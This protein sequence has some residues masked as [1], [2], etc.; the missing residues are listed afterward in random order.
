MVLFY[1]KRPLIKNEFEAWENGPVV[2]VVRDAFKSFGGKKITS[3]AK[4]F[5]LYTGEMISI[6]PLT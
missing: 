4:K 3:R 5:N 6:E 2:K 1:N